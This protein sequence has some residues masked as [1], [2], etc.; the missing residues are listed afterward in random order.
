MT[1]RDA[2]KKKDLDKELKILDKFISSGEE[3]GSPEGGDRGAGE[4]QAGGGGGGGGSGNGAP[5]NPGGSN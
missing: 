4:G 5:G 1:L 3:G 2:R